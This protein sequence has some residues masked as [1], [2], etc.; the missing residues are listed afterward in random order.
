MAFGTRTTIF[1]D[2]DSTI[3]ANEYSPGGGN[4]AIAINAA[5]GFELQGV[6]CGE[7]RIDSAANL[8]KGIGEVNGNTVDLSSTGSAA[9]YWFNTSVGASLTSYDFLIYD[10]T[11]EGIVNLGNFYPANGGYTPIWCD[12]DQF[13]GTLTLSAVQSF[14][15]RISNN[16]TGSGNKPNS[17]VDN[18]RYFQGSQVVPFFINGTADNTIAFIRTSESNKTTGYNGLLLNQGGVDLFFSK[19][20]VGEGATAGTAVA[21]TFSETDKTFVHVD[22]AAIRSDWLGWRV[23][24]GNASTTFSLD[25]CNFQSSNVATA[26][27]RPELIFTGTAGTASVT[28]CA[29]LGLRQATLTSSVTIDGGTFDVVSCTQGGAEIKNT[30]YRP[31]SASGVAAITDGTFGAT[32][33]HDTVITQVGSGHAFE[34]T[35]AIAAAAGSPPT[36]N[37]NSLEFDNTSF[38]ADGTASA[39]LRNTSGEE[40]TINLVGTSNTPTVINVGAGSNTLFVASKTLTISN[41]EPDTELRIYTYTDI[42]DPTTYTEL[43]GAELINSVPT[44]STFDTVITD[45]NDA[46]KFQVTKSYDSSGGDFGTILVAHNLDFI[47]FREPVTLSSTENTSFTVFQIGDRNYDAGTV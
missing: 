45:P 22:Q 46:T 6:G 27:N 35:A 16:D 28:S 1:N 9:L 44:G 5:D 40:V 39:A 4:A 25:N 17:F 43:A 8:I 37:F 7:F 11:T 42:N 38:G 20:M 32:G 3:G 2:L 34:I 36:L 47:F 23:N 15:F 29:I 19:L 14:A 31:R 21:T 13:S 18:A 24:L 26:V 10:G 33:I 41:I 30:V 12:A